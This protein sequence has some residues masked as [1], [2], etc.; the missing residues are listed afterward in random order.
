MMP[1]C[2]P[3]SSLSPL[4]STRSA[5]ACKLSLTTGS[6]GRPK[7]EQVV[8]AAAADVVDDGELMAF[9][10]SASSAMVTASQNPEIR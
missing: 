8:E 5:P 4:N 9:P 1:H 10:S 2:G 7:R 6:S 3:P